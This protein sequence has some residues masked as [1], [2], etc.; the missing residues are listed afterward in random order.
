[1]NK[2]GIIKVIESSVA[3][4]IVVSVLFVSYNKDVAG[5]S[6]D[7]SEEARDILEE[8]ANN[9]S[10]RKQILESSTENITDDSDIMKFVED[11]ISIQL[12]REAKIC[13]EVSD[14]CGQS[15]YV[16]DVFSAERII[17]SD[18]DTYDPK[19]IRLFLWEKG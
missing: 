13:E 15:T 10:M 3:I 1:M 16:G 2:R 8:L 4:L 9:F 5:T 6:V 18:L 14:A 12:N 11:R 17:S 19:K 7:Y